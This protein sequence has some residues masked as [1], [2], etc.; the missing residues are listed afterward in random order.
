MSH[1]NESILRDAYAAFARGDVPAFLALCTPDISFHVPGTGLLG[2]SHTKD[3][4]LA[5]LGPAMAA[6][7]GSFREEVVRLVANESD[8]VVHAAQ[9]ATRD[10]VERRWT[11]VHWWRIRGGKLAEFREFT[12]DQASFDAAWHR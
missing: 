8:G 9:R 11:A 3:A 6:V 7:G 4:F 5:A 10:G 1:P 2:G 12:D